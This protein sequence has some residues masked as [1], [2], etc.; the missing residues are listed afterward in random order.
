[1]A[2]S[3]NEGKFT[4]GRNEDGSREERIA[5][6][7]SLRATIGTATSKLASLGAQTEGLNNQAHDV[8]LGVRIAS[9]EL[10]AAQSDLRD[11]LN[12]A[13]ANAEV[14]LIDAL[15]DLGCDTETAAKLNEQWCDAKA[16]LVLGGKLVLKDYYNNDELVW[17]KL[18]AMHPELAI[19]TWTKDKFSVGAHVH[20]V[21][22]AEADGDDSVENELVVPLKRLKES[23]VD[24]QGLE[25]TFPG[26]YRCSGHSNS[27]SGGNYIKLFNKFG[28]NFA[29]WQWMGN[30]PSELEESFNNFEKVIAQQVT[31]RRGYYH[32]WSID[33]LSVPNIRDDG[34][35]FQLASAIE[36]MRTCF[37]GGYD[38]LRHN[39]AIAL[40]ITGRSPSD[41]GLGFLDHKEFDILN[42]AQADSGKL[43]PAERYRV[44]QAFLAEGIEALAQ[45]D[46]QTDSDQ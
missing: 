46:E 24:K 26:I 20:L 7:E 43:D 42:F 23:I 30:D 33:R 4:N 18:A 2:E 27:W 40:A 8:G 32:G 11:T 6:I 31:I 38:V 10:N 41:G 29:I 1:M 37:P 21:R 39:T 15:S 5:R 28:E 35:M 45:L 17:G 9:S 13:L 25:N 19:E 12:E 16:K 44:A 34:N 3:D 22:P 14:S 36:V